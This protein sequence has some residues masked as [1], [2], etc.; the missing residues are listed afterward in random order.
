MPIVH[1]A[2]LICIEVLSPED[3]LQRL[4]ERINDYFRMGVE[5][6][7]LIDPETRDAWVALVDGSLQ[8]VAEEFAIVTTPI[9]IPLGQVFAELDEM[10]S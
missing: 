9:R 5:H 3:R 10:R 8:H 6:V 4:Q 2:P 7:W 1:V